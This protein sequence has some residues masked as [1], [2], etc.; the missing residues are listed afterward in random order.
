MD[1]LPD[2]Q[3]IELCHRSDQQ[4]Y[5][6]LLKRYSRRVFSIC[7]GK[8]GRPDDAED[9][10]QE[11]FVRGFSR[12]DTLRDPAQFYPW[13][14]Q[15]ARNLCIDFLR[16]QPSIRAEAIDDSEAAATQNGLNIDCLDLQESIEKLPEQLRIPLLDYYIAGLN[17]S[18]IA[19][20]HG[21]TPAT[22][23]TRL[24]RARKELRRLMEVRI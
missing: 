18:E 10:A 19:E 20:A 23:H 1:R 15:I 22:V 8:V 16:R 2:C 14:T 12:L 21:I 17:T 6:C 24:S 4:A 9:L 11:T 13:L 5:A 7:Y 3:L